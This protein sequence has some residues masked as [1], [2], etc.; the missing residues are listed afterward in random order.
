MGK[1]K[2][3]IGIIVFALFLVG[4]VLLYNYL[5]DRN[6]GS[7][8]T[9]E[10]EKRIAVDF[11]AM[12]EEG[13]SV[14]LFDYFGKPV[15]VNFWASWCPSCKAEMP[16]FNELYKERG[17]EVNF[18]MV[19]MT[20]GLRETV[21][22]GKAHVEEQGFDF[23]VLFDTDSSGAMAYSITS[24][25]TTLFINRDGEIVATVYGTMSKDKIMEYLD[26][27]EMK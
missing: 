26:S 7:E 21:E 1:T 4:A 14:R 10:V 15:V 5:K 9:Y 19:D 12:D 2:I 11:T 6:E 8:A 13:N 23:P 16:D 20:D 18:L 27:E 17:S 3:R 24:I 25:P 22:I